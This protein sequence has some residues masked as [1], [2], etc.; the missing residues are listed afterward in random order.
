MDRMNHVK[1]KGF[2][3]LYDIDLE[4]RPLMVMT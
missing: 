4:M 3:R 1:I 2:R